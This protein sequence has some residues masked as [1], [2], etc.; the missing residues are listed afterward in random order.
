[1]VSFYSEEELKELGLKSYGYNVKISRYAHLYNAENISIG[2]NV[3]IDDFCI[4]SGKIK[5]GSNIHISAFSAL[6]GAGGITLEDF[7]GISS[8]STIYSAIDDFSGEF[9]I[10][11]IHNKSVTNVSY[12]NV[13]LKKYS[14]VG[15]HSVIFPGITIG[16][17]SATGTMTLVN[18]DIPEWSIYIGQPARFLKERSKGLLKLTL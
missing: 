4:L 8:H 7:T 13:I 6:Y 1:M 9:L 16:E 10:G 5:I 11:P 3:R 2:N 14:Q 17:G 15:A 12:G 18:K